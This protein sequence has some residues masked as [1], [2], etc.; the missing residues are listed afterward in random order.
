MLRGRLWQTGQE[1]GVAV[2]AAFAVFERIIER[3]EELKPPQKTCATI[4]VHHFFLNTTP[5]F[6]SLRPLPKTDLDNLKLL[7]DEISHG[8]GVQRENHAKK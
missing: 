4:E 1:I 5:H 6:R 3:G 2:G 8:L 7:Q